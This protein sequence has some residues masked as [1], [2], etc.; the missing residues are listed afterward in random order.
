M[1]LSGL[2]PVDA[3]RRRHRR[4]GCFVMGGD[5]SGANPTVWL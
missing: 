4:S 3:Y 1:L 2:T 5:Q